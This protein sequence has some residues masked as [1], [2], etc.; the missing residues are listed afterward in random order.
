[1]P[2]S[3]HHYYQNSLL[4]TLKFINKELGTQVSSTMPSKPKA[5]GSIFKNAWKPK[6]FVKHMKNK[7]NQST[8]SLRADIFV[9]I[10][11]FSSWTY[12]FIFLDHKIY[13]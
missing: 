10:T 11:M 3:F 4:F 6:S 13:I 1:M 7:Q 5:L 2:Q 12:I 9:Y 8:R